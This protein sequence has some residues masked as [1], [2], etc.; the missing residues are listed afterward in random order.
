[1]PTGEQS[2]PIARA[3]TAEDDCLLF[4]PDAIVPELFGAFSS[5]ARVALT[6]AAPVALD[7]LQSIESEMS[8]RPSVLL[9]SSAVA[10]SRAWF[11]GHSTLPPACDRRVLD[12][13]AGLGVC[14]LTAAALGAN[15][16]VATEIE[17][18]LSA[19]RAS[20]ARNSHLDGYDRIRAVELYFGQGLEESSLG[21][22][23][24]DI[25]LGTDLLYASRLHPL[26]LSTL[27]HVLTPGAST[28]VLVYEQRG[29]EQAFFDAAT[30]EL[31]LIGE[32]LAIDGHGDMMRFFIGTRRPPAEHELQ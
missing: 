14:S 3:P 10:L 32:H 22:E 23:V 26:L 25:V 17:P 24:F 29:G 7:V 6:G 13:G 21:G 8:D 1:M 11:G 27:H 18:A 12:L 16:V 5:A 28:L 19:L 30:R 20:L 9:W 31:G 15:A 4:Q 2:A